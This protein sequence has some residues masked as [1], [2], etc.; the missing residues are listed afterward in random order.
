[1]SLIETEILFDNRSGETVRIFWVNAL[2]VAQSRGTLD[3]GDQRVFD[4]YATHSWVV[5]D[6]QG[7]CVAGYTLAIVPGMAVIN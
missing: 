2:G 7:N 4:T 1:V 6:M 5:R 3:P